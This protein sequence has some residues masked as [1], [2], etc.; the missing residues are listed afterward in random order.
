VDPSTNTFVKEK[1]RVS[2]YGPS[3]AL[4]DALS[5]W[6]IISGPKDVERKIRNLK[7]VKIREWHY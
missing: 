6:A 2:V 1:I 3:A 7:G 4:T 5:T